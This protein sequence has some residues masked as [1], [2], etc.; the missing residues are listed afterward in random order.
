MSALNHPNILNVQEN[1]SNPLCIVTECALC[2]LS[3]VELNDDIMKQMVMTLAYMHDVGY[4][5]GDVKPENYLLFIDDKGNNVVKLC[6][7]GNS[8]PTLYCKDTIAQYTQRY[9]PPECF[10]QCG[11]DVA[12]ISTAADIWALGM[13]FFDMMTQFDKKYNNNYMPLYYDAECNNALSQRINMVIS[14]MDGCDK[15]YRCY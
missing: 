9:C 1:I 7:F 10:I 3:H 4:I 2:G 15:I 6:D 5:H 13:S 11:G 14:S 12:E 8:V